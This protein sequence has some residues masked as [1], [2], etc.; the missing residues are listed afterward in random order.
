[1][2]SL[3]NLLDFQAMQDGLLMRKKS[4][5][6]QGDTPGDLVKLKKDFETKRFNNA[7]MQSM[8]NL[9][10][11]DAVDGF[12]TR[13]HSENSPPAYR[14]SLQ[15]PKI[16]KRVGNTKYIGGDANY[17]LMKMKSMG[18]VNDILNNTIKTSQSYDPFYNVSRGKKYDKTFVV[19]IRL[20]ERFAEST[21]DCDKNNDDVFKAPANPMVPLRKEKSSSSIESMRNRGSSRYDRLR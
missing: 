7:K 3:S 6:Q 18:T 5:S 17:E 8:T 21:G 1:M 9:E 10:D 14:H 19:P 16:F 11:V 20:D 13:H 12:T 4:L 15:T 2:K